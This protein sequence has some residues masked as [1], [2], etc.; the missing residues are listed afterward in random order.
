MTTPENKPPVLVYGIEYQGKLHSD[1]ELRLPTIGDNIAVFEVTDNSSMLA[2]NTALLARCLTKLG[3]IPAE[4]I[5]VELLH[6]ELVDDDYDVMW[7][8]LDALKKKRQQ[9]NAAALTGA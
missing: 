8:A 3:T 5:T 4:E 9:M 6:K 1:F 7:S 2:V